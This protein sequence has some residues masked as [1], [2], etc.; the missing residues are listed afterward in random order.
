MLECCLPFVEISKMTKKTFSFFF[1]YLWEWK[2]EEGIKITIHPILSQNCHY[3]VGFVEALI[4]CK[5]TTN[6]QIQFIVG[7]IAEYYSQLLLSDDEKKIPHYF[8]YI[9]EMYKGVEFSPSRITAAPSFADP[10]LR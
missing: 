7:R 3:E 5:K 10:W 2:V 6:E 4:N 1:P 8:A 9:C